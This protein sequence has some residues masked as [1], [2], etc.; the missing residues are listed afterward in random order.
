MLIRGC[1]GGPPHSQM[2]PQNPPLL[3]VCLLV[4]P[5][6][7]GLNMPCLHPEKLLD[8]KPYGYILLLEG[9]GTWVPQIR[10]DQASKRSRCAHAKYRRKCGRLFSP[11][12]F[13]V[14]YWLRTV[15]S[16]NPPTPLSSA[17]RLSIPMA[18]RDKGCPYL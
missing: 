3:S 15:C 17:S 8:S 4:A 6:L 16:R 9:H 10:P 13:V 12:Y 14:Q 18:N 2:C 7:S 11:L 5:D 1:S